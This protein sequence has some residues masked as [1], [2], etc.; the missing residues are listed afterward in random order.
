MIFNST[1]R[2]GPDKRGIS[3]EAGRCKSFSCGLLALQGHPCC[4]AGKSIDSDHFRSSVSTLLAQPRVTSSLRC[5]PPSFSSISKDHDEL[6]ELPAIQG[7][8]VA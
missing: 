1:A 4:D 3:N 5:G 7:G 2:L 8:R 6:F